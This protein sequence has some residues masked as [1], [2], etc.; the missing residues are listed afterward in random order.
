MRLT[1]ALEAGPTASAMAG[2]ALD[3]GLS[4]VHLVSGLL[5]WRG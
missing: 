1:M 4:G 3:S 2:D 5:W